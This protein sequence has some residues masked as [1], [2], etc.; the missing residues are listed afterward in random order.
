MTQ[1][2]RNVM[3]RLTPRVSCAWKGHTCIIGPWPLHTHLLGGRS[4]LSPPQGTVLLIP[5]PHV[6]LP[7]LQDDL[8]HPQG[9]QPPARE[10]HRPPVG[11]DI[12]YDTTRRQAM[13]CGDTQVTHVHI[14]PST[15]LSHPAQ[16][17]ALVRLQSRS[18]VVAMALSPVVLPLCPLQR[19]APAQYPDGELGAGPRPPSPLR[20]GRN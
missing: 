12:R 6:L 16:C 20:R 15:F 1:A 2:R 18:G 7:I 8:R 3:H 9:P 17:T 4:P 11:Q 13:R 10:G 5:T 19:P 14:Q